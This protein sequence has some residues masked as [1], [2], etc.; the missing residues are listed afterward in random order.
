[1]PPACRLFVCFVLFLF[2][3]PPPRPAPA[4]LL[5]FYFIET[6]LRPSPAPPPPPRPATSNDS[7][8]LH[9]IPALLLLS[10]L[11]FCKTTPESKNI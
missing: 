3:G 2:F 11:I 6:L 7:A 5:H 8:K 4:H 1:M 9:W 10:F